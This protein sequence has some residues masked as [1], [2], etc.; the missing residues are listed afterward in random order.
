M[1]RPKG[2]K[3]EWGT[4][5]IGIELLNAIAGADYSDR[6]PV[7][8]WHTIIQNIDASGKKVFKIFRKPPA[9]KVKAIRIIGQSTSFTGGKM[10]SIEEV[11]QDG[12]CELA[13]IMEDAI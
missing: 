9:P 6:S 3:I 10:P 5:P 13:E 7:A 4:K 2:G 11:I 8:N 1:S 12:M